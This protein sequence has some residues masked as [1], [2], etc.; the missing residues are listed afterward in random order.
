[1]YFEWMDDT[2]Q[3]DAEKMSAAHAA[4]NEAIKRVPRHAEAHFWQGRLLLLEGKKEDAGKEFA[5]ALADPVQGR[6]WSGEVENAIVQAG[7]E[8]DSFFESRLPA[9]RAKYGSEHALILALR[10]KVSNA[11]A[12]FR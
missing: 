8:W 4:L 5:L 3:T 12:G 11:K 7:I 10:I 1:C 2:K 6:F 9:D